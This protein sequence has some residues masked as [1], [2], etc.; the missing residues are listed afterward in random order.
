MKKSPN[1]LFSLVNILT[2]I[3][4]VTAVPLFIWGPIL[5]DRVSLRLSVIFFFF[6]FLSEFSSFVF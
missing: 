6:L 1:L 4:L 3:I 5:V 2:A